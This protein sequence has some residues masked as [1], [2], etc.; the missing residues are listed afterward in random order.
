MKNLFKISLVAVLLFATSGVYANDFLIKVSRENEKA[1]SIQLGQGQH[2][3]LSLY[4]QAT[5]EVIYVQHIKATAARVRTYVLNAFPD[6]NY[7]L[8]LEEG[9]KTTKYQIAIKNN[10]AV[11]SEPVVSEVVQ[12]VL[13]KEKAIVTL[14][15]G[16]AYKGQT[17]VQ[18]FNEYNE[19]VYSE[20]FEK[21]LKL[22]KKFDVSKTYSKE[23]TFVVK[24]ENTEFTKT[25][26]LR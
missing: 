6:G 14:D 11:I 19:E 24:A 8:K 3:E 21:G 18:I 9:A 12:P 7:E 17:E 5:D 13:T 10:K 16:N 25:I 4:D 2:V 20:T 15:L 1:I 23:L 22:I 26:E